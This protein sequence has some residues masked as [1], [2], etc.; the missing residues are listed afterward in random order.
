MAGRADAFRTGAFVPAAL[1]ASAAV[2]AIAFV[3]RV[4]TYRVAP[5]FLVPILWAPVLLRRR[6]HLHPFHY[7]LFAAAV[8]LHCMGAFGYYQKEVAGLSFDIYVH[9]YFA[10]AGTFIVERLVRHALPVG[11][12]AA[13][14]MTLLFMMGFG[15]IHELGEYVSYLLLGEERGMLKPHTSYFFDTQRDLLNN[16]LGTLTALLLIAISRAFRSR[17]SAARADADAD[18]DAR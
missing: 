5:A 16:L 13:R 15:A 17:K 3:A 10:F 11:P 1:L 12:W 14:A 8:L 9:F 6:L 4:P 2:L 7:V 18:A